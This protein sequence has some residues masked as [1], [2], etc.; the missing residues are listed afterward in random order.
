M[1]NF[2]LFLMIYVLVFYYEPYAGTGRIRSDP[3]PGLRDAVLQ[4]HVLYETQ[5]HS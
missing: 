3:E 5:T 4:Q 1:A 2:E